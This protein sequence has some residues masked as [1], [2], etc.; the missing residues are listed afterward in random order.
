MDP[1]MPW[2]AIGRMDDEELTA[3]HMYLQSLP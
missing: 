3:M 1:P 2:Q